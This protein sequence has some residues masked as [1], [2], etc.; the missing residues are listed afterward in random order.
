[1]PVECWPGDV[2]YTAQS[3]LSVVGDTY[4]YVERLAVLP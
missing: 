3:S 2:F 1:M 4:V